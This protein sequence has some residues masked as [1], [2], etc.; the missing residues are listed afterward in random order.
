MLEFLR[1]VRNVISRMQLCNRL[2]KLATPPHANLLK[3]PMFL[4]YRTALYSLAAASLIL[5]PFL[6]ALTAQEDQETKERQA[7]N[8]RIA[9][10]FPTDPGRRFWWRDASIAI[11]WR[12]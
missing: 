2:R 3:A 12:V 7:E 5:T 10:T 11:V 9:A 8:R 6:P 1:W 4:Y